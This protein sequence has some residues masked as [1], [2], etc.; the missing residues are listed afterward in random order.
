MFDGLVVCTLLGLVEGLPVLTL[1]FDLGRRKPIRRCRVGRVRDLEPRA[2]DCVDS[3]R[4]ALGEWGR[5]GLGYG[6]LD[7]HERPLGVAIVVVEH[8][9]ILPL[10]AIS[11]CESETTHV[12]VVDVGFGATIGDNLET[13]N[14]ETEV[15]SGLHVELDQTFVHVHVHPR[16]LFSVW[17]P[18]NRHS[19]RFRYE[20]D[21]H[22]IAMG[23]RQMCVLYQAGCGD[24]GDSCRPCGRAG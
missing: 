18:R 5:V 17:V 19:V 16:L 23:G 8:V 24:S 15:D 10:H 6:Q 7:D 13:I 12:V 14:T 21:L 20:I 1:A 11:V 2:H 3:R 9:I 4:I 22:E